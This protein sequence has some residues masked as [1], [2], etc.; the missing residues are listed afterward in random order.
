MCTTLA[1][2]VFVKIDIIN[3][4][5]LWHQR[6]L[7]SAEVIRNSWH[8]FKGNKKNWRG[9]TQAVNSF[10]VLVGVNKQFCLSYSPFSKGWSNPAFSFCTIFY[11]IAFWRLK[12]LC[13]RACLEQSA[14]CPLALTRP[15]ANSSWLY[16]K[17]VW[18]FHYQ[19]QKISRDLSHVN[20]AWDVPSCNKIHMQISTFSPTGASL[21]SLFAWLTGEMIWLVPVHVWRRKE[22]RKWLF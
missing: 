5:F 3:V 9:I 7:N 18:L 10:T 19:H 22:D 12:C 1:V 21:G 4:S 15:T 14:C 17:N 16:S 20:R 8:C 6:L 2:I 13:A 11:I